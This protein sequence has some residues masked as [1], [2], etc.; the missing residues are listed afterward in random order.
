MLAF[1]EV[2]TRKKRIGPV[3]RFHNQ[4]V[5]HPFLSKWKFKFHL[6]TMRRGQEYFSVTGKPFGV[7]ERAHDMIALLGFG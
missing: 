3:S 2:A 6:A 1:A 4:K 5:D 7:S